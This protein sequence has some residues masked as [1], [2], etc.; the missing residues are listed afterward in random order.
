MK[1]GKQRTSIAFDRGDDT[2]GG[3]GGAGLLALT[4]TVALIAGMLPFDLDGLQ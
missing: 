2:R 4:A 3:T 1:I